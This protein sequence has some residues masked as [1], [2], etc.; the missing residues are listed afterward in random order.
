VRRAAAALGALLL[1]AC[2]SL[3]GPQR[4]EQLEALLAEPVVPVVVDPVVHLA[5]VRVADALTFSPG[6]EGGE[7]LRAEV[8]LPRPAPGFA[9]AFV[10]ALREQP[11]YASSGFA[12]SE[13]GAARAALLARGDAPVFFASA[14]SWR[15][16]YDLSLRRYR[17]SVWVHVNVTPAAN[18]ASDASFSCRADTARASV[19][20]ASRSASAPRTR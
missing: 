14:G 9:E 13:L 6:F 15:L 16:Y 10:A 12:L 17:M 8:A 18:V 2:H 3:P 20:S 7:R 5:F 19:S 1:A 4:R 11:R